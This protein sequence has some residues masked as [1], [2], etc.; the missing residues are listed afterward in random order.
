LVLTYCVA[1]AGARRQADSSSAKVRELE[2]KVDALVKKLGADL[3]PDSV[4]WPLYEKCF[5][6][7]ADQYRYELCLFNFVN[8]HSTSLGRFERWQDG[9]TRQSYTNGL[10]CWQG[11][12]RSTQVDLVCGDS[13]KLLEV[14][15]PA[16]CEYLARFQTPA[17]CDPAQLAALDHTLQS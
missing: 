12:M 11:P 2:G 13:E 9:H 1:E 14:S 16:K 4:Y 3:G 8:Q 5:S 7:Q 10:S 6:L 15:E 17:A